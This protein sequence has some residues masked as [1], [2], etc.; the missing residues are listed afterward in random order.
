MHIGLAR[1]VSP[2]AGP[3][4]RELP[5]SSLVLSDQGGRNP[6]WSRGPLACPLL[7]HLLRLTSNIS[8]VLL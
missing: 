7:K 4:D 5:D 6:L 3:G 1:S 8:V 2:W